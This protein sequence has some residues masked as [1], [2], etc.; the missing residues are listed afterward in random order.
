MPRVRS[1]FLEP[2]VFELKIID[3]ILWTA[4][5]KCLVLELCQSL[6]SEKGVTLNTI[7]HILTFSNRF[8][9]GLISHYRA[10]SQ[11][12]EQ[13]AIETIVDVFIKFHT[14]HSDGLDPLSSYWL[15]KK[16][17][18]PADTIKLLASRD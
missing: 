7:P 14:R 10:E 17:L 8:F 11:C 2:E 13:E 12:T 4:Q 6:P 18:P 5:T 15:D 16:Q 9:E 3:K 1:I